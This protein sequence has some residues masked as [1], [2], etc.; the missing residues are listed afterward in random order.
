APP[1]PPAARPPKRPSYPPRLIPVADN[2]SGRRRVNIL[3]AQELTG[4]SKKELMALYAQKKV[5]AVMNH[6]KV[7]LFYVDTLPPKVP[8]SENP[9]DRFSA[10][11]RTAEP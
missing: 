5:E 11:K 10:T 4:L 6:R 7:L 9:T 1:A 2:P 3:Q 8:K